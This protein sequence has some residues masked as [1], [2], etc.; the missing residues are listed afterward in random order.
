MNSS[1]L[2]TVLVFLA[3]LL[4]AVAASLLTPRVHLSDRLGHLNLEADVPQQLGPWQ[5][6]RSGPASVVNPQ[7][8]EVLNKIYSQTLARTYIN[9]QGYRIMLSVAYG[10]DQRDAMQVHYPEVCYPAQGFSVLQ[11]RVDRIALVKNSIPVR[12]LETSL[13]NQRKEPVTYWITVGEHVVQGDLNKKWIEMSYGLKGLIPDGLLFRVS[14]IDADTAQAFRWQ[15]QFVKDMVQALPKAV[16]ARL[17]GVRSE[18]VHGLGARV[19]APPGWSE[20]QGAN[21]IHTLSYGE[22]LQRS[23]LL[24]AGDHRPAS[25]IVSRFAE[26]LPQ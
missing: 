24:Q 11:N 25:K 22:D 15:D 6:D 9:P 20:M 10:G 16:L 3:M 23:K 14:S 26:H 18:P 1:R 12:R 5:L 19:V 8:A 21:R 2:R 4:T 13:G 17:T 7:T